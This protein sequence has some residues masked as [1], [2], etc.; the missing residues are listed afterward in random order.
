MLE[1]RRQEEDG[2]I[3]EFKVQDTD[4]EKELSD[5]VKE[6]LAQIDRQKYEVML[7]EKG[8]PAEKIRKYGFAFSGK[9]VLIGGR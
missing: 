2:I 1:P 3:L 9:K 6:A 8:V 5:T 7:M 4:D